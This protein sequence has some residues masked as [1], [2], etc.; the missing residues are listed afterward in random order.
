MV[1]KDLEEQPTE[2][3]MA[4]QAEINAFVQQLLQE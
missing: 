3:R 4:F 2:L 1:R